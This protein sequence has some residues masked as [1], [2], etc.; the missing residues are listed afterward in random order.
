MSELERASYILH[1][2][3]VAETARIGRALGGLLVPGDVLLLTGD[4]GAGKTHLTQG[5]AES[6]LIFEPVTSPTFN[7]ELIYEGLSR[8]LY[9]FDL[10]RLEDEEQLEQLDF[11]GTIEAGGVTVVEWGDRFAAVE[12]VAT[13]VV[14]IEM[15]PGAENERILR[16]RAVGERGDELLRDLRIR[17]ITE[18][19]YDYVAD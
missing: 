6:M 8:I 7:L 5:I 17:L 13:A 12:Q 1:S 18:G 16:L 4:L 15:V 3:S 14:E 2:S 11:F 10:Y 19:A 9:H